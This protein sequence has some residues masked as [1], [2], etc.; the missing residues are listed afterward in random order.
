MDARFRAFAAFSRSL[1][2]TKAAEELR[3]SQPVVSKHVADLSYAV[4]TPLVLRT[5]RRNALTPA[6][7]YFS[8]YVLR[9]EALLE[10]AVRGVKGFSAAVERVSIVTSGTPGNYIV[11]AVIA[12]FTR[13]EPSTIIDVHITT[14]LE[15]EDAVRAHRFEA[16]IVGAFDPVP[17]L[18]SEVL[19][20]D[21][22]VLIGPPELAEQRIPLERLE[23]M[24][25]IGR[26]E[27]AATRRAVEEAWKELG[28]SPTTR[29][30]LPSREAV[31]LAVAAGAGIA[32][33]TRLALDVEL[34]AG[35]LAVLN[36]PEWKLV[37]RVFIIKA[38]ETP[39]IP[40]TERFLQL[41]RVR[42]TGGATDGESQGRE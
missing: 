12:D 18:E 19:A 29:V 3:I 5:G 4:G 33:S 25:W 13:V 28:I 32:A 16:G 40:A 20:E 6:G 15:A 23:T 8:N 36:V 24:A 7:E 21:E 30:E 31:K 38:R 22:I 14:A 41:A 37:R 42:W 34:R 11:P 10:Q 17:D 9:A 1:S 27:G 26:E 35:T 2:Y 39:L